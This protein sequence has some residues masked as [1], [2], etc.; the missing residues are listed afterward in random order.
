[1]PRDARVTGR[2]G[3][4]TG[5]ATAV[6]GVGDLPSELAGESVDV[7]S[8]GEAGDPLWRVGDGVVVSAEE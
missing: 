5:G 2:V 6:C 8:V 7:V 1:M 4:G 3:A